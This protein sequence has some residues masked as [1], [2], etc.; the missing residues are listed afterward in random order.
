MKSM[1]QPSGMAEDNLVTRTKLCN[2]TELTFGEEANLMAAPNVSAGRGP[3][4][5]QSAFLGP[6]G[7]S[8]ATTAVSSGRWSSSSA[9]SSSANSTPGA[10]ALHTVDTVT[11]DP[12]HTLAVTSKTGKRVVTGSNGGRTGLL[13]VSQSGDW[14]DRLPVYGVSN[15]EAWLNDGGNM[16]T[17]IASVDA[18]TPAFAPLVSSRTHSSASAWL[19]SC[20]AEAHPKNTP[21]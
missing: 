18:A 2:W 12:Y 9:T 4:E 10:C 5:V 1:P 15:I 17:P 3:A 11:Q 8:P 20:D 16:T 14:F 6:A 19:E 21:P 13:A 7:G